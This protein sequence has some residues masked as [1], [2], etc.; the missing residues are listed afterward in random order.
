M[1]NS[2]FAAWRASREEISL[3]KFAELYPELCESLAYQESPPERIFLYWGHYF[4][5]ETE[6]GNFWL[7]IERD[8]HN[9]P[10]LDVQEMRLWLWCYDENCEL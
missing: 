2:S 4:I 1:K 8:E 5:V 3:E 7:Y 10:Y 6:P 9:E